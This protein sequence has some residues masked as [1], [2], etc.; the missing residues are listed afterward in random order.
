[1][2]YASSE[3][4]GQLH[5]GVLIV[6]ITVTRAAMAFYCEKKGNSV[7]KRPKK[8]VISGGQLFDLRDAFFEVCN[9]RALLE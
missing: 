4:C 3:S 2:V 9:A 7:K 8:I 5:K 6:A 1:M